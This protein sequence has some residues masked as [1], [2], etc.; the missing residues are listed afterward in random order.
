V[1]LM[2]MSLEKSLLTSLANSWE[3]CSRSKSN[4][5][6]RVLK[7]KNTTEQLLVIKGMRWAPTLWSE[8]NDVKLLLPILN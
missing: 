1:Y 2:T 6:K 7:N 4:N 5:Y 3:N 8:I